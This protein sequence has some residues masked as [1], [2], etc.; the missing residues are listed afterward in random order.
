MPF[1]ALNPK[2]LFTSP[3]FSQGTLAKGTTYLQVGGQNGADK[4][5]KMAEGIAAQT[6][7]ALK[8]V[9]AVLAEGGATPDDVVRLA[10]YLDASVDPNEAYK[11]VPT[12]WKGKPTAV[13]VVKVAGLGRPGGLV[14]IEATA[15]F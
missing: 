7:Q 2:S 12:V 11:A 5:G 4:E 3:A 15:I 14:E 13:V 6:V 9:L 8:N 1:D 10:V